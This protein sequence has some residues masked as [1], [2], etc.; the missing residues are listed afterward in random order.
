MRMITVTRKAIPHPIA[1][2]LIRVG[3]TR[4]LFEYSGDELRTSEVTRRI[5]AVIASHR[6]MSESVKGKFKP[7]PLYE[8]QC[9]CGCLAVGCRLDFLNHCGLACSLCYCAGC[10]TDNGTSEQ[11]NAFEVVFLIV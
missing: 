5:I 7:S 9:Y 8:F 11:V 4:I 6:L 1:A 2:N 10:C 3:S